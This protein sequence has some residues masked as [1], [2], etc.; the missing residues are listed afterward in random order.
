MKMII[1]EMIPS[2]SGVRQIPCRKSYLIKKKV[3]YLRIN[4]Y[5]YTILT[6][7]NS[8]DTSKTSFREALK[9][10]AP[11]LQTFGASLV[12]GIYFQL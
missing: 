12:E 1:L 10:P 9:V 2:Q 6:I 5:M 4:P 7:R 8:Q 3:L 11:C